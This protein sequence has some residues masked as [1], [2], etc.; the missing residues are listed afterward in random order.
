MVSAGKYAYWY[1]ANLNTEYPMDFKFQLVDQLVHPRSLLRY[2]TGVNE[3]SQQRCGLKD[4][5]D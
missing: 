2:V 5:G 1:H 4:D 3:C